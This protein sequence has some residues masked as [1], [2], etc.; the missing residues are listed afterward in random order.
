MYVVP[1][2]NAQLGRETQPKLCLI[3]TLGRSIRKF[4]TEAVEPQRHVNICSA[5]KQEKG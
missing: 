2:H 4:E 1:V 5:S 3:F